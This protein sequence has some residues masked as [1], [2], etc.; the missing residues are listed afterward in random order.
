MKFG[1]TPVNHNRNALT[2]MSGGSFSGNG[3]LLLCFRPHQSSVLFLQATWRSSVMGL[4]STPVTSEPR[5][6]LPDPRH[7]RPAP[8]E[9]EEGGAPLRVHR[10]RGGAGGGAPAGST[11]KV[12]G[13]GLEMT[14]ENA[15]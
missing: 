11:L 9:E 13:L 12:K 6:H 14:S 5:F 1:W 15:D 2:V 3:W 10:N 8:T 4:D 7:L